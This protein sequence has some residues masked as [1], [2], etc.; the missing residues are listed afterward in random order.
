[1]KLNFKLTSVVAGLAIASAASAA[2][3][4]ASGDN[5]IF[6]QNFENLYRATGTCTAIPGSCLAATTGDPAGYRRINPNVANNVMVN[7]LFIGV[8][9]VQNIDGPDGN[10]WSQAGGDRFT[11]YFVQQVDA[12]QFTDPTNATIILGT[13]ADPFGILQAGEMFR[14]FAGAST[15]FL[16]GGADITASVNSVT[17]NTFWA[18]FG[19]GTEGYAYTRTDLTTSVFDSNTEAFLGLDKLVEGP[20]YNLGEINK[21]NDFNESFAG[22]T[23]AAGAAQVCTAADLVN[24]AVSCTDAVGTSE[25][26]ANSGF[27]GFGGGNQPWMFASNDPFEVNKVP[28]PGSL[29]LAGLALLGLGAARRSLRARA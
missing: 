15:L 17:A 28:A 13:A 8:L 12:I 23:A 9:N 10:I 7:D 27:I 18:S 19:L 3:N 1:M 14:F 2:P 21:L 11:G 5:G 26:E 16:G 22:G 20:A 24:A 4:F 6:F 29:A 25:I